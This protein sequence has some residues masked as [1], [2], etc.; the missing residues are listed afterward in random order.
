MMN[1]L[2]YFPAMMNLETKDGVSML[3]LGIMMLILG[4]MIHFLVIVWYK[5]KRY[6]DML[7]EGHISRALALAA[8]VMHIQNGKQPPPHLRRRGLSPGSKFSRA[9]NEDA[10][11]RDFVRSTFPNETD[12]AAKGKAF[13]ADLDAMIDDRDFRVHPLNDAMIVAEAD[14]LT[15]MIANWVAAGRP[16]NMSEKLAFL[17]LS[18]C[19]EVLA[20]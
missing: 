1:D 14:R 19:R 15:D 7:F 4:I 16:L 11:Y 3:I 9:W 18:K 12:T 5:G 2:S 10:N 17:V 20:A 8:Q 6:E 13:S